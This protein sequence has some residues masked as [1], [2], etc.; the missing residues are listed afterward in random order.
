MCGE[1]RTETPASTSAAGSSP[2][3][4]GTHA[5]GRQHRRG[6]RFIPACAGNSQLQQYQPGRTPVHPRVCGELAVPLHST[7]YDPGSSPRVRGT[8]GSPAR[9]T[10]PTSVHPR[11]CG[12]L[13]HPTSS[14]RALTGSSPRVRGTRKELSRAA[15]AGRSEAGSSPRVRGTL[16]RTVRAALRC[17]F[18]PAC[19]GNSPRPDDDRPGWPVHPRVCGELRFDV[20]HEPQGFGSSPRVRGT[21]R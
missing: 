15:S 6:R 3:V 17:R 11:V 20:R 13:S 12:E 10:G 18:I 7:S 9:R 21:P 14:P 2:R 8:R 4:R 16:L 1:L 19:A 5:G